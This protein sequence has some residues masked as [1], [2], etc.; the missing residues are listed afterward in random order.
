M[1]RKRKLIKLAV[2]GTAVAAAALTLA[3]CGSSSTTT[4]T[5][6]PSAHMVKVPGG[7][8][9]IAEPAASGPNYIF[10][11]MGGAYFSVSDF[12]MVYT[13]YRP[14]YWFGVGNTPL[15]NSGLSLADPPVYSNGGKT[16]TIKMKGYKW[17][18][19][20]TVDA[21]DVLFW[22][23]MLK[24]EATSWAGYAPGPNQYPG[25]IVNVVANNAADTVTITANKAYSSYWFTYNELSQIT[26]LPIAWDVTKAGAAP[27]SGGCSSASYQSV[28]TSM[29]STGIV[30]VSAAAKACA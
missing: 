8:L 22:S 29:G 30:P 28:T 20:E 18:N 27:G 15:F 21:Q 1:L 17:S 5:T 23:N 9:T 14:L 24:A 7:T 4:T 16:I 11:M 3:A 19:G 6:S 10:P 25:D 13:L 26:P 2:V 12:T